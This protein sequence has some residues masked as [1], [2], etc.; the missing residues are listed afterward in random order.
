MKSIHQ[1]NILIIGLGLIGGSLARVFSSHGFKVF[2]VDQ[3]QRSLAFAQAKKWIVAGSDDWQD[4]KNPDWIILAMPVRA[5][6]D[7]IKK[8][9]LSL[10]NGI[11]LLD[12]CSTKKQ[13]INAMQTINSQVFAIGGHPMCGKETNGVQVADDTLFQGKKFLFTPLKALNSQQKVLLNEFVEVLGSQSHFLSAEDHDQITAQISHLPHLLASALMLS[14]AS[15]AED[16]TKVFDFAA[17]GFESTTRIAASDVPMRMD[18]LRTNT[19][20]ILKALE[21]YIQE[22]QQIKIQLQTQDFQQ[23]AKKLQQ[24][25]Q[26]R[27]RQ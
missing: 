15:V 8:H 21:L 11:V 6:I 18:I 27:S 3:N 14:T 4:F 2:A 19:L 20:P 7:W 24:A 22:L 1:S 9:G 23:L 17:S 5:T 10:S 12:V 16:Q 13:V 26:V 25:Q